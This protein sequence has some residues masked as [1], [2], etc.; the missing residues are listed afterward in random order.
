M[1]SLSNV[2]LSEYQGWSKTTLAQKHSY[3]V[4]Q[5]RL[6]TVVLFKDSVAL[7]HETKGGRV[8]LSGISQLRYVVTEQSRANITPP[9][10]SMP[11]LQ[12]PAD[13]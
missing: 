13:P 2:K 4:G 8:E 11:V 9:H 10:V 1:H 3:D 7:T 12:V 5:C 6:S